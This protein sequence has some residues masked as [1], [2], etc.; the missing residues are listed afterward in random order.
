MKQKQ[1]NVRDSITIDANF[2]GVEFSVACGRGSNNT[3]SIN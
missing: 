1:K 3:R 2:L